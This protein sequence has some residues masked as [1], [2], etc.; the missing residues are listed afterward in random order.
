[1]EYIYVDKLVWKLNI[2]DDRAADE[3]VPHRTHVR[4]PLPFD[5]LGFR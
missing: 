1:M 5:N 3:A 4:V 2:P